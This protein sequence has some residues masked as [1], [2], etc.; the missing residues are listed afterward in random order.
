MQLMALSSSPAAA[1][2]VHEGQRKAQAAGQADA[3]AMT[4]FGL[5]GRVAS[6]IQWE[7]H[8]ESLNPAVLTEFLQLPDVV[9]EVAAFQG[10]EWRDR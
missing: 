9:V 7:P 8:H 4:V 6:V 5:Q 1:V 3:V 10:I 2:L